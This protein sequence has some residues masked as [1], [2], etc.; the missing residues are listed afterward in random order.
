M[1]SPDEHVPPRCD[2]IR[3]HGAANLLSLLCLSFPIRRRTWSESQYCNYKRKPLYTTIKK[4]KKIKI[5]E[6]YVELLKMGRATTLPHHLIDK[7]TRR[8]AAISANSK[9]LKFT[10]ILE[11][12]HRASSS[13]LKYKRNAKPVRS[14]QF[15]VCFF[16]FF[17]FIYADD[18][19]W[20]FYSSYI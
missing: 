12:L 8:I 9:G 2:G 19:Y 20:F 4:W 10:E 13:S 3:L 11:W 17:F 16:L 5:L 14:W 15:F 6:K 7:F 1:G 18:S